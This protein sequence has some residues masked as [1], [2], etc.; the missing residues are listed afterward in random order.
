MLVVMVA[1]ETIC[2][3][4]S[5]AVMGSGEDRA[6]LERL[7]DQS[8]AS[9]MG[10]GTLR[11][12]DPE[13]RGSGGVLSQRRI[14]AVLSASGRLPRAGKRLFAEGPRPLIFTGQEQ[15]AALAA[16]FADIADVFGLPGGASGLSVQAAIAELGRRGARSV[17]IEGGGGLNHAALREGV[18]DEIRLTLTPFVSGDRRAASLADG[19]A[20]LGHPF[21]PLS[22]LSC[23]Q[24]ESGELFLH[25]SVR[26]RS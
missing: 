8:D 23:T 25:Y 5:P 4:I 1:A 24:G 9:L 18:V 7:R 17:L 6:L 13:M 3:R 10:A 2:G 20:P 16:E 26:K 14:R 21:L 11:E 19:A 22:L 12:A 15:A